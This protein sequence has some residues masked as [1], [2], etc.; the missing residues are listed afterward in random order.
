MPLELAPADTHRDDVAI[1]LF[2]SGSTGHPK[3]AVHLHHDLPFNAEVYAKRTL[4][5]CQTDITVS[6]PKLFSVTRQARICF[7]LSQWAAQ[8]RSLANARRPKN[9]RDDRTLSPDHFDERA[10]DD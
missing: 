8:P 6:V 5:V 2:T 4:G 3:G 7:S 10:D 9:V 1:W